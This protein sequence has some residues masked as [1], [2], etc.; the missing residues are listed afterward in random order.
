MTWRHFRVLKWGV[1][2]RVEKRA[3]TRPREFGGTVRVRE[4]DITNERYLT[5]VTFSL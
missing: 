2:I 5:I 3:T 4:R 1:L